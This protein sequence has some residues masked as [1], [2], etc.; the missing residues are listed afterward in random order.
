MSRFRSKK[1]N[2]KSLDKIKVIA[3]SI[4]KAEILDEANLI[5][6]LEG[7]DRWYTVT[8]WLASRLAARGEMI[9]Q[10]QVDGESYWSWGIVGDPDYVILMIAAI[11]ED[12]S[13]VKE[14]I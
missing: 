14:I 11:I 10:V 12:E 8:L 6:K 4:V 13:H 7:I 9:V 3:D 5:T 1:S 2:Q